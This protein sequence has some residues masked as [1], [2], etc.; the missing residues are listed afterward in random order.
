MKDKFRSISYQAIGDAL[1]GRAGLHVYFLIQ[2]LN[3]LDTD[4]RLAFIMPAD[5]CEGVFSHKLWEWITRK[6]CLEGV[7][8]FDY[9]ASPFPG[10]IQTP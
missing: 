3:L 7:V 9:K 1:D 8:T 2:A 5:T 6:Y 10:W 4:G